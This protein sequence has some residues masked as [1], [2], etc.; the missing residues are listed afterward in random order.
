MRLA[1]STKPN[2]KQMTK[3]TKQEKQN[4]ELQENDTN[5]R[6]IYVQN[7]SPDL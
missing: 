4:G 3:E 1:S 7:P 2:E 5:S 6:G